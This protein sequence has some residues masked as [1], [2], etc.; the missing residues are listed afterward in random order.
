[1][2][3]RKETSTGLV[4][5]WTDAT[6]PEDTASHV[7]ANLQDGKVLRTCRKHKGFDV[8]ASALTGVATERVR[9]E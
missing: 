3:K 6:V 8:S 4:H 9:P 7:L 1:V 2:L 5:G